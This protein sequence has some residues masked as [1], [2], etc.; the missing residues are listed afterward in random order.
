[1]MGQKSYLKQLGDYLMAPVMD[2]YP[3]TAGWQKKMIAESTDPK[4]A[5]PKVDRERTN[6]QTTFPHQKSY[7]KKAP[8]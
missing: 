2:N 5:A 8:K 3:G 6:T 1:M 7:L 4:L